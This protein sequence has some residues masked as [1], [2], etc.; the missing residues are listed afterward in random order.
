LVDDDDDTEPSDQT[1]KI[2]S[3]IRHALDKKVLFVR[4]R[5][6]KGAKGPAKFTSKVIIRANKQDELGYYRKL[7]C[8]QTLLEILGYFLGLFWC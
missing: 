3:E 7:P 2:L 5:G 1:N 8:T 4:P 6:P